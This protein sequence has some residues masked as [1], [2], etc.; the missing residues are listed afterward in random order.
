MLNRDAPIVFARHHWMSVLFSFFNTIGYSHYNYIEV[1]HIFQHIIIHA[2]RLYSFHW[3][4]KGG[5][6]ERLCNTLRFEAV[7]PIQEMRV[8]QNIYDNMVIEACKL[9]VKYSY[10]NGSGPC[11]YY[12]YC[13]MLSKINLGRS[14]SQ[15]TRRNQSYSWKVIL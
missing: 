2:R 5:C 8:K 6:H 14:N 15:K 12:T 13:Y 3:F 10:K 4:W 11:Y 7:F 1:K 9:I